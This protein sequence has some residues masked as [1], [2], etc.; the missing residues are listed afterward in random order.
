LFKLYPP[1]PES[2]DTWFQRW[3]YMILKMMIHDSKDDTWLY[4]K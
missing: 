3:W 4:F 1:E 2:D